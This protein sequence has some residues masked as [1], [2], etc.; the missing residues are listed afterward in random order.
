MDGEVGPKI[1]LIIKEIYFLYLFPSQT[2]RGI[3][4]GLW[5]SFAYRREI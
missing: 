2:F 4:S 3:K 1:F 5:W